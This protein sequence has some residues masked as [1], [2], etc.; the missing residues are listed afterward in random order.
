[1]I[2]EKTVETTIYALRLKVYNPPEV[3]IYIC[4]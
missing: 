2:M 3:Y 1:M 4:I